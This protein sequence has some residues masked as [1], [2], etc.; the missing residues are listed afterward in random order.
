MENEEKFNFDDLLS[1]SN[2]EWEFLEDSDEVSA[3][4]INEVEENEEKEELEFSNEEVDENE[5]EEEVDESE[6]EDNLF[7]Y[8][9]S[10][11]TNNGI[12]NS[13]DGDTYE[14]ADDLY[15]G[16]EKTIK[17]GIESWKKSLGSESLDYIEYLEKGGDPKKYI[18][19]NSTN[20]F[21]SIDIDASDDNKKAVIAAFYKEKGFSDKKIERLIE[22]SEDME[23]LED[24]AKEALEYFKDKKSKEKENLIESAKRD[25]EK[26]EKDNQDFTNNVQSFINSVEEVRS[27]PL[28]TKK[29]KDDINSY[30]FDKNVPFKQSDGSVIK[31]SQYMYDKFVRNQD[32]KLK[33]EDILFDA[34]VL[35]NGTE[36]IIKKKITDKNNKLQELAEQYRKNPG[37][38]INTSTG[39]NVTKPKNQKGL[40]KFDDWEDF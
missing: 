24:E 5:E 7:S 15:K 1:N 21:S 10:T 9:A 22:N 14:T 12:L 33:M 11:L 28:K 3:V 16:I 25:A 6:E 37:N 34:L 26:R 2:T 30:I 23:V 20:D 18:E 31:I 39:K 40:K 27:F 4:E 29:Q 38:R 13:E 17:N 32:E 35:K 8:L 36:P 19:V